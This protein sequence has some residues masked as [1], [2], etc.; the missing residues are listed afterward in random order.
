MTGWD[1][2][3]WGVEFWMKFVLFPTEW[4]GCKVENETWNY[5]TSITTSPPALPDHTTIVEISTVSDST[6][7]Q[8]NASQIDMPKL[9]WHNEKNISLKESDG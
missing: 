1:Y 7:H 6:Q 9:I 5:Y 8:L 3:C 4:Q 2:P